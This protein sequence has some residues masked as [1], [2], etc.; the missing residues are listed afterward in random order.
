MSAGKRRNRINLRRRHVR[1]REDGDQGSCR[2]CSR[3][4]VRPCARHR[5]QAVDVAMVVRQIARR[6]GGPVRNSHLIFKRT[7][8]LRGF[9]P[10]FV[11]DTSRAWGACHPLPVRVRPEEPFP[12]VGS[13][14]SLVHGG[15]DRRMCSAMTCVEPGNTKK[16]SDGSDPC[17]LLVEGRPFVVL[18]KA[19]VVACHRSSVAVSVRCRR[20]APCRLPL[21]RRCSQVPSLRGSRRDASD[22][23][24]VGGEPAA[25]DQARTLPG[26][27]A[28]LILAAVQAREPAQAGA[29]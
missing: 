27:D 19:L 22:P 13:L 16:R 15:T 7:S 4:G 1:R 25:V 3:P 21:Q 17:P 5:S 11:Q 18:A 26:C 12:N 10:P 20:P 28:C 14:K 9:R 24:Q 8:R 6:M 23:Q 29:R 2:R